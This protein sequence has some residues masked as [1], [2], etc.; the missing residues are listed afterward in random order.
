MASRCHRRELRKIWAGMIEGLN[1]LTKLGSAL[2]P[3]VMESKAWLCILDPSTFL[4]SDL[5]YEALYEPHLAD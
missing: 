5:G 1:V 3:Q 4:F 2:N